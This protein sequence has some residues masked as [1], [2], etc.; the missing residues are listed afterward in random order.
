MYRIKISNKHIVFERSRCLKKNANSTRALHNLTT[1]KLIR[2]RLNSTIALF[3]CD[4]SAVMDQGHG[5][6]TIVMTLVSLV[7]NK[8]SDSLEFRFS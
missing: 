6:V 3:E 1:D 2:L 7:M 5:I 4:V 8:I